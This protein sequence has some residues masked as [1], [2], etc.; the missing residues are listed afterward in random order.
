MMEP[1]REA[2]ESEVTGGLPLKG[3][4]ELLPLLVSLLLGHNERSIA[5]LYI[6]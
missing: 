2:E 4:L 1:L 3:M 5:M 6:P